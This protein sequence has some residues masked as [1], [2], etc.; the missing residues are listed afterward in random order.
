MYR[1]RICS[2]WS[3]RA[4]TRG[5]GSSVRFWP[6]DVDRDLGPVLGDRDRPG[7]SIWR[8]TRSAVRWRVPVS[9]VGMFGSGT[10][11]TLARTMRAQSAVRMIAPSIFASSESRC[12]V[13]SASSRKPPE[14][15]QSTSGPAPMTMQRA[16]LGLEDALDALAQRRARRHET[17]GGEHRFGARRGGHSSGFLDPR[18]GWVVRILRPAVSGR[19]GGPRR[20]RRSAGRRPIR[21]SRRRERE[22]RSASASVPDPHESDARDRRAWRRG[23]DRAREAE[24]RGLGEPPGR[25]RHLAH[26]AAE[27]DLADHDRAGRRAPDSARAP[28]TASATA[29][30]APGSA[31]RTPPATLA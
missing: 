2:A 24:A 31:T 1:S 30:S 28:A 20:R 13:N 26:L 22:R 29:R 14:Q 6:R 3:A 9:D 25:A 12:G 23:H 27:S 16:H 8:A 19:P 18:A 11:W 10:R 7:P 4:S 15:T 17:Q 5:V 21:R